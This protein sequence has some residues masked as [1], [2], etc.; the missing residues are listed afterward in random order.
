[1]SRARIRKYINEEVINQIKDIKLGKIGYMY[2]I[3][4]KSM[5]DISFELDVCEKTI[6]R[7][8][9]EIR[10]RYIA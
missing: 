7:R 2:F 6:Q 4:H 1:M 10:T 5:L 9:K 3:E 8:I